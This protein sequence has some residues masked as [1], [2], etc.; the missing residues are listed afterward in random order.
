MKTLRLMM[1][2]ALSAMLFAPNCLA[3]YG[4]EYRPEYDLLTPA[5]HQFD[6]EA[7]DTWQFLDDNSTLRRRIDF[8]ADSA[9]RLGPDLGTSQLQQPE[10]LISY[11]FD[12]VNAA[13]FQFRDFSLFR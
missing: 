9:I 4:S 11:W 5:P 3:G 12:R 6:I 13:Q 1:L 2:A 10:V 7:E 8:S